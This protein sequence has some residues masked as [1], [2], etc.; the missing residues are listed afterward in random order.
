[1]GSIAGFQLGD[2]TTNLTNSNEMWAYYKTYSYGINKLISALVRDRANAAWWG[3]NPPLLSDIHMFLNNV[4]FASFSTYGSSEY[5]TKVAG[6]VK[7][8]PY[9][10][11]AFAGIESKH[12]WRSRATYPFGAINQTYRG[13]YQIGFNSKG[14]HRAYPD[15]W[16]NSFNDSDAYRPLVAQ[17]APF[18]AEEQKYLSGSPYDPWGS[19]TRVVRRMAAAIDDLNSTA[20]KYG[21]ANTSDDPVSLWGFYL[22]WNQGG[23]TAIKIIDAYF[24]N[25]TQRISNIIGAKSAQ[26]SF[27]NGQQLADGKGGS[28]SI[29]A[30]NLTVKDWVN[31]LRVETNLWYYTVCNAC[32]IRAL[33]YAPPPDNIAANAVKMPII[34]DGKLDCTPIWHPSG[35]IS[36]GMR[37]YPP[38]AAANKNA[39]ASKQLSTTPVGNPS[40]ASNPHARGDYSAQTNNKFNTQASR[41][42]ETAKSNVGNC[43]CGFVAGTTYEFEVKYK[44]DQ[45][46]KDKKTGER[47]RDWLYLEIIGNFDEK[48]SILIYLK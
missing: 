48:K 34:K 18:S 3:A 39:Q 33:D 12:S 20:V 32:V 10:I 43:D 41:T 42:R 14:N 17:Y 8:A 24:S 27:A 37:F 11:G 44:K 35:A 36:T 16:G 13:A 25:P 28:S 30:G 19:T 26:Q 22:V 5:Y 40:R 45:Q 9:V 47:R 38:V 4:I 2:T 31:A 23:T 29:P 7:N 21:K 1:M 6:R 15:I 46:A